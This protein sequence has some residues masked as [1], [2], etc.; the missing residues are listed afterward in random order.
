MR[1]ARETHLGP[2][3]LVR[4]CEELVIVWRYLL[5]DVYTKVSLVKGGTQLAIKIVGLSQSK[6]TLGAISRSSII[7]HV[8]PV[9]LTGILPVSSNPAT[10]IAHQVGS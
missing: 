6:R 1:W 7:R 4:L 5:A 10:R 3:S 8:V 2:S 9:K